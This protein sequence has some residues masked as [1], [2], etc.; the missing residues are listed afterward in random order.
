MGEPYPVSAA[1]A[2][3]IGD[4]LDAI[5]DNF[6]EKDENEVIKQLKDGIPV[7]MRVNLRKFRDKVSG[8]LDKRLYNY[9]QT[10]G[11]NYLTKEEALNTHDIY[12]H[13]CM[14]FT[15]VNIVDDKPQRWKIEDSYG[16]SVHQNGYYIMNDNYFNEYVFEVLISKKYL[17]L[18]Q[19]DLLKQKPIL[20]NANEPF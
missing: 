13:H 14:V 4:V 5:Y 6:P 11:I 19:L 20:M 3:G 17:S 12:P 2:L 10:L 18:K 7:Y 8:V 15:G 9:E 16:T 1:N